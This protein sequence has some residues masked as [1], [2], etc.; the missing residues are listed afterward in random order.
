MSMYSGAGDQ[1]L[2][3]AWQGTAFMVRTSVE[4][5]KLIIRAHAEKSIKR[6]KKAILAGKSVDVDDFR[7]T[8]LIAG[9]ES[10]S[11]TV[12]LEFTDDL[13]KACEEKHIYF[14]SEAINSS[15]GTSYTAFYVP[16][17][18]VESFNQLLKNFKIEAEAVKEEPEKTEPDLEDYI[19]EDTPEVV[20]EAMEQLEEPLKAEVVNLL[21]IRRAELDAEAAAE[22]EAEQA[23]T[24]AS[25]TPLGNV[26]E[27]AEPKVSVLNETFVKEE[28]QKQQEAEAKE[29]EARQQKKH[30]ENLMNG[31]EKLT[32]EERA[33]FDKNKQIP[34]ENV[35]PTDTYNWSDVKNNID[36]KVTKLTLEEKKHPI[37]TLSKDITKFKYFPE[38]TEAMILYACLPPA[39]DI[40]NIQ[41]VDWKVADNIQAVNNFGKAGEKYKKHGAYLLAYQSVEQM[42]ELYKYLPKKYQSSDKMTSMALKQMPDLISWVPHSHPHY[43]HFVVQVLNKKPELL[44]E[45]PLQKNLSAAIKDLKSDIKEQGV[46]ETLTQFNSGISYSQFKKAVLSYTRNICNDGRIDHEELRDFTSFLKSVRDNVLQQDLG[47]E[48]DL[49]ADVKEVESAYI[50]CLKKAAQQVMKFYDDDLNKN[51][52]KYTVDQQ[53]NIEKLTG[54]LYKLMFKDEGIDNKAQ[55]R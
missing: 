50:G 3:F 38:Q 27:T 12:P 13:K 40:R 28:A 16:A 14:A 52:S 31:K 7:K 35:E 18:H 19:D 17:K 23:Q 53:M 43:N 34:L 32:D 55:Q 48:S 8:M 20:K 10:F 5:A 25:I 49:A 37:Q 41:Y 54:E 24:P 39:G 15:I 46:K 1:V 47:T 36:S 4:L 21:E 26:E 9:E 30:E 11:Y 2:N 22:F 44:A 45:V 6:A 51:R 42:P 29:A 33:K